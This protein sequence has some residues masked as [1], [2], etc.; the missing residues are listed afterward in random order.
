VLVRGRIPDVQFVVARAPYLPEALF[1]PLRLLADAPGRAA[2]VVDGRADDVLAAADMALV[3]SGTV[4]VQAALHE[5]PMV[6]VYRLSPL[7]YRMGKPFVHVDTYAMANLVAGRRLV[8][9]LIQDEFTPEAVADA[10][11]RV[12]DDPAYAAS[13]RRDLAEV[14]A[15]LGPPGASARAAKAVLEVA[16]AGLAARAA[17]HG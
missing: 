2:V 17:V 14:R 15:K 16:H 7:T 5:C 11:T 8:P 3:A 6:V 13:V 1:A 10:A 9:E 12:L 4:T